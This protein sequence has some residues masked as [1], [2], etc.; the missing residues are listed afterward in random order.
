[1]AI[2]I[3]KEH[4]MSELLQ[5]REQEK[6]LNEAASTSYCHDNNKS[7]RSK[8][9]GPLLERTKQLTDTIWKEGDRDGKGQPFQV[10]TLP[11]LDISKKNKP[12]FQSRVH[13]PL[14]RNSGKEKVTNTQG[15][16]SS[17]SSG[18]AREIVAKE[19]DGTICHTKKTNINKGTCFAK[20]KTRKELS[21]EQQQYLQLKMAG[22]VMDH[23]SGKWVKDDN[24]EF[25]SDE[26][27]P[28]Q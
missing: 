16:L 22:W 4:D 26:D 3:E 15:L 21:K 6:Y 9:T 25:D 17:S 5:K 11:S 20:E 18:I 13:I 2:K 10:K 27:D 8:E 12:F 1:M 23:R 7:A 28:L 24:V 19:I 14:A